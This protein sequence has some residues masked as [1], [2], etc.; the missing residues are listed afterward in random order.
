MIDILHVYKRKK[1]DSIDV[2]H[3]W[4]TYSVSEYIYDTLFGFISFLANFSTAMI[5][6]PE[7]ASRS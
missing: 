7:K 2:S 6:Q 5:N 1:N 4:C 3:V